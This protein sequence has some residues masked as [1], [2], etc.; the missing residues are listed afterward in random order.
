MIGFYNYTVYMTY[1]GLLISSL[2]ISLACTGYPEYAILCLLL[3]GI[4]D[5]FDGRIARTRKKSNRQ[6]KS[7]GIQ[8]DSLSDIVCFGV[9]PCTIGVAM[10]T[11][12]GLRIR[13][14]MWISG[15]LLVL[16]ALIRLAYFNVTEEERQLSTT[17]RRT[18]YLGLPVTSSAL[19]FPLALVLTYLLPAPFGSYIYPLTALLTAICFISPFS[20]RK[21]HGLSLVLLCIVG[22]LEIALLLRTIRG[23]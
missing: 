5:M 16:C 22:L 17:E 4:C 2:G 23:L 3:S 20:V 7:F 6:E 12:T 21:P 18:S 19:I 11:Q 1:A 13:I 8:L 10:T 15:C 14:F 9:L